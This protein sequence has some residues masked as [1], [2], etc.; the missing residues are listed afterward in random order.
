MKLSENW[1]FKSKTS[2]VTSDFDNQLVWFKDQLL[3]DY[4]K[5]HVAFSDSKERKI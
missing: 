2:F 5:W 3:N 4:L 1:K